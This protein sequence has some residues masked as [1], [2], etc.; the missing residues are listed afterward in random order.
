MCHQVICLQFYQQIS[1]QMYIQKEKDIKN[2]VFII[3]MCFITQISTSQEKKSKGYDRIKDLPKKIDVVYGT[4]I[5][6]DKE[7]ALQYADLIFK[8]R[9]PNTPFDNLKPYTI[10]LI[11][12]ERVWEVKVPIGN[13][14][15]KYYILRI[16]KNTGEII[17]IWLE[18]K[19]DLT[20][21]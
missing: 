6:P 9:Y 7:T 13:N 8:T 2:I 1:I 12:D 16:N 19:G 4:D 11:A 3:F 20:R 15:N 21:S 5:I 14:N 17:N 10:N 18:G